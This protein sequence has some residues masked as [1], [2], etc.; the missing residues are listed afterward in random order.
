MFGI[1]T[2]PEEDSQWWLLVDIVD[3]EQ[4]ANEKVTE[5][6]TASGDHCVRHHKGWTEP[7]MLKE[8]VTEKGGWYL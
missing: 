2:L 5:Y 6:H 8:E 4:M 1:Y 7:V 3:T